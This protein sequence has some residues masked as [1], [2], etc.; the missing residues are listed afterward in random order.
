[1]TLIPDASDATVPRS[2]MDRVPAVVRDE[3]SFGLVRRGLMVVTGS[4]LITGLIVA[5]SLTPDATGI[6]THRQLGL[7][8]C[9]FAHVW[10]IPCP[11]CGMTTAWAHLTRGDF[12]SAARCNAGGLLAGLTAM[13]AGPWMLISGLR[14]RWIWA[15]PSIAIVVGLAT[16]TY[17]TIL[18]Q[19]LGRLWNT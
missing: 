17:L 19:W 15:Q 18:G 4:L 1:M 5:R 9:G 7:P 3:R 8:G 14:G 11:S 13:V 10:G 6:G 16:I 2:R 12:I